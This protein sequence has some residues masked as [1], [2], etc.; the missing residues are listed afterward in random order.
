[1]TIGRLAPQKN[2]SFLIKLIAKMNE[3]LDC[4]LSILGEGY[5]EGELRAL[6]SSLKLNSKIHFLGK[7]SDVDEHLKRCD[8]FLFAS[9]YEGF[10]LVL[11]EAMEARAKIVASDIGV[12]R[13]VLGEKYL[14]LADP[15]DVED[16]IVEIKRALKQDLAYFELTYSERL[17]FF[18]IEKC[19]VE[20]MRV[21]DRAKAISMGRN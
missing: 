5:L 6:V 8:L 3:E 1:L 4:S 21:Y 15:N 17:Q 2:L 7:V 13:E 11:L 14:F 10:G 20:H 12:I 18:N 16:F 9:K 19:V